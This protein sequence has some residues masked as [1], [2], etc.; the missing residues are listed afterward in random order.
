MSSRVLS[1]ANEITILRLIFVPIFAI[2]VV[3]HHELAAL[4]V[5]GAAAVSDAADGFVARRFHQQTPLGVALDPIADKVLM[6]TA[7]LVLAFRAFLPWWLAIVVISRDVCILLT[8][9]VISL[10]AGYRPFPPSLLGKA[11]T[12]VQV[13]TVFAALAAR[14]HLPIARHFV[15]HALIDLTAVLAV[16]SGLHYLYLTR[17]RFG[18]QGTAGSD[19]RQ[20][21]VPKVKVRV[22]IE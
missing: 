10:V 11:S 16:A 19:G 7:F 4:M 3:N 2:L 12:S 21:Q 14:V 6:T 13:L 5:L 15:V 17:H 20:P 1:P 8:A 18:L 22:K 9:A